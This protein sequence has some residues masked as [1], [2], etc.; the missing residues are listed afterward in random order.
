MKGPNVLCLF[1]ILQDAYMNQYALIYKFFRARFFTPSNK[2]NSIS[3]YVDPVLPKRKLFSLSW[4]I[5]VKLT[6]DNYQTMTANQIQ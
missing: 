3:Y 4:S 1:F 5:N 6:F 2:P